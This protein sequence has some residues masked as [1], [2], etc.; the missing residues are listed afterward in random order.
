MVAVLALSAAACSMKMNDLALVSL[1]RCD[2][3]A[4]AFKDQCQDKCSVSFVAILE[5]KHSI[6]LRMN[7]QGDWTESIIAYEP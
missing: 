4:V 5:P 3:C 2:D 1:H 6:P 7:V